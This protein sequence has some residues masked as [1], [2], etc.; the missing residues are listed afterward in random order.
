MSARKSSKRL[1]KTD[2]DPGKEY[3]DQTP[4]AVPVRFKQSPSHYD[5]IK[6]MIRVA[7]SEHAQAKD[8]E[9]FDEA[10]DFELDYEDDPEFISNYEFDDLLPETAEVLDTD[11]SLSAQTDAE[12]DRP[13]NDPPA[14]DHREVGGESQSRQRTPAAETAGAASQAARPQNPPAGT[15]ATP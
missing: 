9:T 13:R 6:Q 4:V 3:P 12:H 2:R 14:G 8:F 15:S 1:A 7:M 5:E 11:S 10:N